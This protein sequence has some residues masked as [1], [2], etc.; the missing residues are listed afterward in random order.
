MNMLNSIPLPRRCCEASSNR[1][2]TCTHTTFENIITSRIDVC[3]VPPVISISERSENP[4]GILDSVTTY[5]D[6]RLLLF[7]G[8]DESAYVRNVQVN[9]I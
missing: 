3:P 4:T 2:A 6:E 8:D 9:R 7:G 1:P 5:V